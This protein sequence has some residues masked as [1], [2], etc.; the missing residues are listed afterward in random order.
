MGSG[1]GESL[2]GLVETLIRRADRPEQP[3][4]EDPPLERRRTDRYVLLEDAFRSGGQGVIQRRQDHLLGREVAC[5]V[6]RSDAD[7]G[8][9]EDFLREAALTAQLQH[10]SVVPVHDLFLEPDGR[11][12]FAMKLIEG[13]S[14]HEVLAASSW[15]ISPGRLRDFVDVAIKICDALSFAHEKG[16]VHC[17]VKPANVMLGPHGEVLLLDWG[18]AR[19]V[20]EA[21]F[22]FVR[23]TIQYMAP[24]QARG[25]HPS[26]PT[27]DVFAMGAVLFEILE[28]RPLRTQAGETGLI[29][30]AH[31]Q[32]PE[33]SDRVPSGLRSVLRRALQPR[34]DDRYAN[35]RELKADLVRFQRGGLVFALVSYEPGA[36]IVREGDIGEEAYLIDR[37]HCRV[38]VQRGGEPTLIRTMGPGEVFGELALLGQGRRTA[39]V[40][41]EDTVVLQVLDRRTIEREM[42]AT[43]PWLA[44]LISGLA[45]RLADRT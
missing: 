37:G 40:V 11:P 20:D 43:Q 7:P 22:D 42:E 15:P 41:A 16:F 24:E 6:L 36:T 2:D 44:R 27:I 9:R 14:L 28:G 34:P 29:E 39:T 33:L 26:A 4:S 23:G 31:H 45:A 12:S 10:P 21:D 17:D 19:R 3:S 32:L 35:C 18:I 38:L 13:V 25:G 30:A 8:A 5:K 1:F